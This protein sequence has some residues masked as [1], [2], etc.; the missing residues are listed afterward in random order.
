M[1]DFINIIINAIK[2]KIT[3]L[4]TTLRLWTSL[5]YLQTQ[6]SIK[7]RE[8]F[9]RIFS[10]KP[11]HKD[12]YYTIFNWLV[13]K[14]LVFAVV[15]VTGMVSCYYLCFIHPVPLFLNN[16][17]GIRVYR[18]DSLPLRFAA[19]KVK[20]KAKSGYVAYEGNVAGGKANGAGTLYDKAGN[21]IYTGEFVESKYHGSGKLYG[22]RNVLKYEG[23]FAEN[24][25]N[26]EG[27]LY[28]NNGS[29]EYVGCFNMG[30]KEGAGILYDA[31]NNLVYTGNFSQ[32][33]V[34]YT[35]LLGKAAPEISDCYSGTRTVYTDENY[36]VVTLDD[37]NAVYCG[38]SD[39]E[40]LDESVIIEDLYVLQDTIVVEGHIC[41]T[42]EDLSRVFGFKAYEG[43]TQ[44]T[45][46]EAVAID[47]LNKTGKGALT[48]VNLI[49]EDIFADVKKVI[50]YEPEYYVYLYTYIK[51]EVI[52][53]FFFQ[54]RYGG[55]S[56]YLM[57]KG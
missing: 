57:E 55:F 17:E 20:I 19:E 7:I 31:G 42:A 46:P 52:Y 16:S 32:D 26:G 18:Y 11:R 54:E 43:N 8:F 28:R 44:I 22:E 10:V 21:Y 35:D 40:N 25:F 49:T 13:S 45:V 39:K 23:S 50:S 34:L 4:W 56:M 9:S 51:E 33:Q 41:R 5:S 36:F 38:K 14:R 53:T 48:P 30:L 47:Q 15:L 3:S 2:A 37:I 29:K 12:D 6:A 1:P 27:T 24:L